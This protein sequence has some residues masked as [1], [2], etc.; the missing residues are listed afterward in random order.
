MEISVVL[1]TLQWC[2]GSDTLHTT[3]AT[4][5]SM[6]YVCCVQLEVATYIE[7]G[8]MGR[9]CGWVYSVTIQCV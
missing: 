7:T 5:L 8:C 6:L 9:G 2:G 1:Y 4:P 3:H